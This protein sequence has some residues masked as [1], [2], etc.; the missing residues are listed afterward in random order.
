MQVHVKSRDPEAAPL[1]ELAQRR[2]RFVMRRRAWLV[3]RATVELSDVNGPRGGV[4]KRCQVALQPLGMERVV[5]TAVAP[6]W[7]T[8][9]DNALA[10][11]ARLLLRRWH[12]THQ[13]TSLIAG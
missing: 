11:A 7:R 8:A 4:D 5:I 6:D 10:R 1:R 12:R 2:V 3:T 13:H 9:L